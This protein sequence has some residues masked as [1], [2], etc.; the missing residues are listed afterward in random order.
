MNTDG[1][2]PLPN[3]ENHRCFGCSPANPH[4]LQM[5]FL[6]EDDAVIS[7]LAVPD[8]LCGWND[9]VH[10]GVVSTILDEIMSRA[11]IYL[12]GRVILTKSMQVD[13]LKPVF[14]GREITARGRVLEQTGER[15]AKIRGDLFDAAGT[16]CARSTGTFALFTPDAIRKFD[17]MDPELI[18]GLEG[19]IHRDRV[20]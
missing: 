11:A 2:K 1:P 17:F 6:A 12:L 14:T 8:H 18:D 15:E 16:R 7:R 5:K 19:L 13:F 4:G 10:G 20:G 9:V 3:L